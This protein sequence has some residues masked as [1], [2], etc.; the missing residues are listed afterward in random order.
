M[1][2]YVDPWNR[3]VIEKPPSEIIESA[4][5]AVTFFSNAGNLRLIECFLWLVWLFV[6]IA[7]AFVARQIFICA[8]RNIG[9]D[10]DDE[11]ACAAR[12]RDAE[13]RELDTFASVSGVEASTPS[14]RPRIPD[15]FGHDAVGG[16]P[17]STRLYLYWWSPWV[18]FKKP[19]DA[20]VKTRIKNLLILL[21]IVLFY[22][23]ICYILTVITIVTFVKMTEGKAFVKWH[24]A[25]WYG[26]FRSRSV[27]TDISLVLFTLKLQMRRSSAVG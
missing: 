5:P 14:H 3:T 20:G 10:D 18:L 22:C 25:Y 12:P 16:N 13:A 6:V 17:A 21:G 27:C 23:I 26:D 9:D 4:T 8:R 11:D 1:A 15:A 19:H 24:S 7:L 2:G